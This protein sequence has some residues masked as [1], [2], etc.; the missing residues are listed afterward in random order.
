MWGMGSNVLTLENFFFSLSFLLSFFLYDSLD[1]IGI[2]MGFYIDE[3]HGLDDGWIV[4]DTF[5]R[6]LYDYT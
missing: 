5:L 3:T 1:W 4:M 2:M 6:L